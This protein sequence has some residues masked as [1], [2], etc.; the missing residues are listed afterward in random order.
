ME[1]VM[2]VAI[3]AFITSAVFRYFPRRREAYAALAEETK[4]LLMLGLMV[5]IVFGALGIVCGGWIGDIDPAG[6]ITLTCDRAGFIQVMWLLIAAVASNQSAH[7][8][9]PKP[10][11]VK[12]VTSKQSKVRSDPGFSGRLGDGAP[13]VEAKMSLEQIFSAVALVISI[14]VAATAYVKMKPERMLKQAQ[15][16]KIFQEMLTVEIERGVAK[17]RYIIQL[18]TEMLALQCEIRELILGRDA[19]LEQ[20]GELEAELRN[21]TSNNKQ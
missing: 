6:T 13:H 2:V 9:L 16:S 21:Y 11:S 12:A 7:L 3:A 8:I 18:K 1:L 15:S 4:Q 14:V 17:D 5:V 10:A 20:V 19:L